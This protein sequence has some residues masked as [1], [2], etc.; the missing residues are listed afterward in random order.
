[1]KHFIYLVQSFQGLHQFI[2]IFI[3]GL[4][5]LMVLESVSYLLNKLLRLYFLSHNWGRV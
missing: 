5:L 2:F 4:L 1:M 3:I